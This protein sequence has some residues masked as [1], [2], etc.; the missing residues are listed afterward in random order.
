MSEGQT[1]VVVRRYLDDLG[2][3]SSAEPIVRALLA[4]SHVLHANDA[5]KSLG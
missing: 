4:A 3:N 1:T 5:W 2:E